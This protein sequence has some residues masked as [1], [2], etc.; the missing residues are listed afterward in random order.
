M[1][2]DTAAITLSGGPVITPTRRE[3]VAVIGSQIHLALT[4]DQAARRDPDRD[5]HLHR[6][7]VQLIAEGDEAAITAEVHG[8]I[9]ESL[10][11]LIRRLEEP[12]PPQNA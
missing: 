7:L 12:Q 6:Q 1:S 11:E 8:H 4:V 9:Q 5:R 3:E 2:A 10:D